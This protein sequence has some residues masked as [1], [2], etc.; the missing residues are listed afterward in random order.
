MNLTLIGHNGH[1][2]SMY[3]MFKAVITRHDYFTTPL[4]GMGIF[5]YGVVF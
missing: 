3:A 5:A 1:K 4:V 2:F